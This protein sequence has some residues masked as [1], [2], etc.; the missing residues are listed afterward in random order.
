MPIATAS[1]KF[2]LR[3][4]SAL[5]LGTKQQ[6]EEAVG[7]FITVRGCPAR[8]LGFRA[9]LLHREVASEPRRRLSRVLLEEHDEVLTGECHGRLLRRQSGDE[10]PETFL[11]GHRSSPPAAEAGAPSRGSWLLGLTCANDCA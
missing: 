1:A 3:L 8:G 6:P 2:Y 9:S 5:R 7:S 11:D 4:D 10:L